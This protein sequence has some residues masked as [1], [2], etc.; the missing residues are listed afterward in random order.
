MPSHLLHGLNPYLLHF[1]ES[2]SLRWTGAASLV[3][4]LLAFVWLRRRTARGDGPLAPQE[5]AGFV[6]YASLFGVMLGGRLGYVLLHQWD[7]FSRDGSIFF[8]F[9]QGGASMPGAL[10]GVLAFTAY[11]AHQHRRSWLHLMDTLAVLAPLGFLLWHLAAFTAG[12]PLGHVSTAPWAL[13]FPAELNIDGFQPAD[14]PALDLSP[15]AQ[16]PGHELA[17]LAN[18]SPALLEELHRVLPPRHP[19][20]LYQAALEGLVLAGLLFA[21]RKRWPELPRGMMS[22][23][24]FLLYGVLACASLPF[25]EPALNLP[26]SYQFETGVPMAALMMMVGAAFMTAALTQRR[27]VPSLPFP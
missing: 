10:L 15:L 7:D 11:S 27:A 1:S 5:V 21:L 17:R 3:G 2:L 22:G 23:C 4:F 19:V 12:E 9:R 25:R 24:F 18:E 26:V 13:R 8:Q 14:V 6:V 20:L 16:A